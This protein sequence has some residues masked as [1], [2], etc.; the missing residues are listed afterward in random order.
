MIWQFALALAVLLVTLAQTT[1]VHGAVSQPT[2]L[3]G[4]ARP[5]IEQFLLRQTAGLP[6][7]VVIT[8]NT[9]QSGALPP[10]AAVEP[11]LPGGARLWGRV[12]VGVRCSQDQPWTRY[13]PAY[14]AVMGSYR[15]AARPI[16][17]G[18]AVMPEDSTERQGDL[19]TLPGS[20]VRH[21]A[22]LH[23][24]VAVNGMA[25]G[26]PVRQELLRAVDLVRQGQTVKVVT[27]GA[28][29]LVSSVGKAMTDSAVGETVQVKM[30]GGQLLSGTVRP[31]GTVERP[32]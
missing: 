5:V 18:Q 30:Q 12:S 7:R 11:F 9:P 15:V 3:S 26:A 13:V 16:S 28:G 20:V 10:C 8:L 27:Q 25:S 4:N 1:P 29:F 19:T 22:Q 31:D 14:I 32:N 24:M 21:A 6:G 2:P 17:A 23:G